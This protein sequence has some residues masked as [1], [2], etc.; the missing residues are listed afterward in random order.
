MCKQPSVSSGLTSKPKGLPSTRRNVNAYDGDPA[1]AGDAAV[2]VV[3][4]VV[5]DRWPIIPVDFEGV[6]GGL[7]K[8]A[9][10]SVPFVTPAN[11]GEEE[12]PTPLDVL[13]GTSAKFASPA[14]AGSTSSS[15]SRSPSSSSMVA[16]NF[17]GDELKGR[18]R[19]EGAK[20]AMGGG[21]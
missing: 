18:P 13:T 10:A 11:F 2:S 16:G 1:D 8:S 6:V 7:A 15:S 19:D 20:G 12:F 14:T 3:L 21:T 5:T 17:D 4:G 9:P